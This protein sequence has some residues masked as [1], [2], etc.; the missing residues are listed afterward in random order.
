MTKMSRSEKT[1]YRIF[2]ASLLLCLALYAEEGIHFIRYGWNSPDN[3]PWTRD[4]SNCQRVPGSSTDIECPVRGYGSAR[5]RYKNLGYA[6]PEHKILN[7]MVF[8]DRIQ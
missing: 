7:S 4:V 1:F 8:V 2:L 6:D 3:S 5:Y